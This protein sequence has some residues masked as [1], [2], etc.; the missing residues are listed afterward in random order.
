[1]RQPYYYFLNRNNNGDGFS[2]LRKNYAREMMGEADRVLLV[3]INYDK[4][5]RRHQCV[6]EEIF[7]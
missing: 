3:G 5:S 7:T 2:E 1:M 6:I 4:S